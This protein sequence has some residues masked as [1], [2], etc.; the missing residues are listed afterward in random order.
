MKALMTALAAAA[1]AALAGCVTTPAGM[2]ESKKPNRFSS[3]QRPRAVVNCLTRNHLHSG[4]RISPIVIEAADGKLE[5]AIRG[6][7]WNLL[8]LYAVITPTANGSEIDMYTLSPYLRDT[9]ET[10]MLKGC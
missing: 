10:G 9:I 2:M 5:Y 6:G 4:G 7:Q 1:I 8:H 3:G